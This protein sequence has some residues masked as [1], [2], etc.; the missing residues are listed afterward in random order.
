MEKNLPEINILQQRKDDLNFIIDAA[1]LGIWNFDPITNKFSGNKRLKE[2]FDL[3]PEIEIDLELVLTRIAKSDRQ[4][5]IN[6]IET[7][8][9][10]AS[11]GNYNIEFTII[12]PANNITRRVVAKGK[13][14]FDENN[15]PQRLSGTLQD[16]TPEKI[17]NEKIFEAEERT[18]LAV[19]SANLGTFDVN[20]ITDTIVNSKRLLEIFG[21]DADALH[22]DLIKKIL[23]E[24]LPIR[25]K[26]FEN[27]F[28]TDMLTYEIR[29]VWPDESIHWISVQGKVLQSEDKKPLRILG[30]V[31]DITEQKKAFTSLQESEQQFR[32]I[33]K[34]VP[35]G[36]TILK[37]L[38]FVVEMANKTY[39]EI[40]DRKESNFVGRPLFDALPEV[41]DVVEALLKNVY[42]TGIP[43]YGFE[44]PATIYRHGKKE[45]AYFNFVYHPLR[46][47]ENNI[48]GIIV[49]ANDVTGMVTAKHKLT[50]SERQF[51][52]LV[53]QSP[54]PM[55]IF[56]GEDFI[57]ELANNVMFKTLWRKKPEDV[58]GKK[59][60][61]V[62]PELR[63]QKYPGLLKE[64]F[65][66]GIPHTDVESLA[67]VQGD[68]GMKKFYLDYEYAPLFDEDKAVYGI[69]ITVN[70]VTEKVEARRKAE[71]AEERARLA[72]N[73]GELG[74][75]EIDLVSNRLHADERFFEIFGQDKNIGWDDLKKTLHK[76]DIIKR[77]RAFNEAV[78]TGLLDYEARF[79]KKDG[80]VCWVKIRGRILLENKIP[81]KLLGIAVDITKQKEFEAALENKV[82]ERTQELAEANAK[83]HQSNIELNQF[84]YI[85]SHDLQEPLRKVK[86]FTDMMRS[87]L[88]EVSDRT[89]MYMDKIRISTERMQNLINDILK[90]SLLAKEKEKFE[91]VNL[92]EILSNTISDYELLIE[93]KHAIIKAGEL[94][95][96][97]A[98]QVQLSQL[99]ANLISNALK[100]SDKKRQLEILIHANQLSEKELN[101]LSLNKN[102]TYY[103]IEFSDNGI[104]FEQESA[105]QIFTIFQRLHGRSEYE[106]T[107]IGLA[108][109]RKIV[110]NHHGI[111]Y[112]TSQVGEGSAFV[113]IIPRIQPENK[114]E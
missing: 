43:Y 114:D 14:V 110:Q 33:V 47:E 107:G 42:T 73:A 98:I 28:K 35:I 3:P 78:Q 113:I 11:G 13:A 56:R 85:A 54:I 86:T 61:H 65:A 48:Y 111:I 19:D 108:M 81:V 32:N 40:V 30:T 38:D 31:K 95:V 88:G 1:E 4:N 29:I 52:N 109:C 79:I 44:F 62:F 92:D 74:V 36:I 34:Q 83:L 104:G 90:F 24:D 68:D 75:Y 94:P 82:L 46:S 41:R 106:G 37:G 112:A 22:V 103:Q 25:N 49:V 23:P 17:A 59:L 26:A 67:Y 87:G 51:R 60:L 18:R 76:D 27:A 93:Q 50:E 10:P 100:F 69:I 89:N 21:L 80:T 71:E 8:L 9:H 16:I 105:E 99:F 15:Q 20:Y 63:S 96:V 58:N 45:V 102:D 39:L 57:V 53:M 91:K 64:V 70:D 6:A 2:W 66:T 12:N 101:S 72:V 7:A 55:A 84:A 97:E 77:T 5:I